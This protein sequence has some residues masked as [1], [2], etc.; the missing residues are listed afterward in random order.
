M[1]PRPAARRT[2]V[3]RALPARLAP[4]VGRRTA[5]RSAWSK[6]S[7]A[8]VASLHSVASAASIASAFSAGSLASAGSLLS[9][10]SVGSILSIGSAGSILS[11]GSSGSILSIGAAGGFRGDATSGADERPRFAL[12]E[13]GA[14][15]LG[16]AAVLAAWRQ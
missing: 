14:S 7:V 8:S 9:I 3:G 11:I 13:H 5:G 16:L 6:H 2:V 4:S 15:L 10:G 12:L 1:V